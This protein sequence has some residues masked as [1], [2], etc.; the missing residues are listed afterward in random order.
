MSAR[1]KHAVVWVKKSE[2]ADLG[3][4]RVISCMIFSVDVGSDAPTHGDLRVAWLHCQ[5]PS[6]LR[7]VRIE[8]TQLYASLNMDVSGFAI[9]PEDLREGAHIDRRA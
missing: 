3:S 8:V 6:A 4:K 5:V 2:A 9:K 1:V 7:Q